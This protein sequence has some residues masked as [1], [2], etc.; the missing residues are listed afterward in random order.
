ML[1]CIPLLGLSVRV[2]SCVCV[3]L[4]CAPV[5]CDVSHCHCCTEVLCQVPL[6]FPSCIP[7]SLF[8]QQSLTQSSPAC[9]PGVKLHFN[10]VMFFLLDRQLRRSLDKT[11]NKMKMKKYLPVS[12]QS[13]I[14]STQFIRIVNVIL[15]QTCCK[16]VAPWAKT[17]VVVRILVQI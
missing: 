6:P 2:S 11:K 4:N 14:T 7:L 5:P 12:P 13:L 10:G 3:C 15:K 16:F 1:I 8:F 9:P 17:L